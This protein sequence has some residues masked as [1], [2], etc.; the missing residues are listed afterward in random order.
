MPRDADYKMS[1]VLKR[2]IAKY[3]K[4]GFFEAI[5][6]LEKALQKDISL[7]H[8]N[9]NNDILEEK[10]RPKERDINEHK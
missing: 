4:L 8:V 9:L 1:L 5:F 3:G 10:K 2:Q 6:K 7:I